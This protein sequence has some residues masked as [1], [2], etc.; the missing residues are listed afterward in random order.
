MPS[1]LSHYSHLKKRIDTLIHTTATA[2]ITTSESRI[3]PLGK[4]R[5]TSYQSFREY[6]QEDY[7][8]ASPDDAL[9]TPWSST[10]PNGDE[11]YNSDEVVSTIMRLIDD[12]EGQKCSNLAGAVLVSNHHFKWWFDTSPIRALLLAHLKRWAS[13]ALLPSASKRGSCIF[14]DI[15]YC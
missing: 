9:L 10:M 14:S 3:F 5:K 4:P 11:Q 7:P 2:I 12:V 8:N 1:F 15:S 13:Q 6:L